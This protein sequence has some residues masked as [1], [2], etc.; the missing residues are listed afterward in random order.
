[1][2]FTIRPQRYPTASGERRDCACG[3]GVAVNRGRRFIKF[4]CARTEEGRPPLHAKVG[5]VYHWLTVIARAPNV[6]R[7]GHNGLRA[8]LCRCKCGTKK[9]ITDRE[10]FI[11]SQ[12]SCGCYSA[13]RISQGLLCLRH[14]M[15]GS[16]E[17]TAWACMR[18]RVK[19]TNPSDRRYYLDRGIQV[20]EG[21]QTFENFLS[22]VGRRPS[23]K[24]SIDRVNND[25]NYSCGECPQCVENNWPMNVRWATQREQGLNKRCTRYATINGVT[26]PWADW[27]AE[28]GVSATTAKR[29]IERDGWDVESALVTPPGTKRKAA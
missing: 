10:L 13:L 29:R 8:W 14:G 5:D 9:I 23:K 12:K 27:R 17:H 16:P 28:S 4:H 6:P 15:T 18:Q 1:M 11:G 2:T 21:W 19:S 3:C 22:S 24:H 20:C 25:G 26:K 7:R